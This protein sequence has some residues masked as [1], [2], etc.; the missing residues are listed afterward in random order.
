MNLL[1]HK[2]KHTSRHIPVQTSRRPVDHTAPM[3]RATAPAVPEVVAR[4][5]EE[6]VLF[7]APP[8]QFSRPY[9]D[10][11]GSEPPRH[12]RPYVLHPSPVRDA[13]LVTARASDFRFPLVCACGND[14]RNTNVDCFRDLYISAE[15]AGWRQ[16]LYRVWRCPRCTRRHAATFGVA[17][18]AAIEAAA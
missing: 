18:V 2:G 5:L 13:V 4:A 9:P 12:A 10:R 6:T 11:R 8:R 1:F 3:T 17:P 15:G 14:H 16:D 7:P